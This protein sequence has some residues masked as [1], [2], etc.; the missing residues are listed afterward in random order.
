DQVNDLRHTQIEPA[1]HDGNWSGAAIAAANGLNQSPSSSGRVL[2]AI[3]LGGIVVVV[4]ALLIVMRYRKRRRRTTALAAARR[5]D[6]TDA[7]ALAAVPLEALDDLSRLMVVD[8]DN[9][10]RTSSNELMLAIDE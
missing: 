1:L 10:V 6:P 2:L 4:A 3:I 7:N 8:V 9:A 5:V